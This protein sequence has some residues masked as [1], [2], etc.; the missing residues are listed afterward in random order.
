MKC[1]FLL[2]GLSICYSFLS[3]TME[4]ADSV[5]YLLA[6]NALA[7]YQ[8]AVM[9]EPLDPQ[10][11]SSALESILHIRTHFSLRDRWITYGKS[12]KECDTINLLFDDPYFVSEYYCT[13]E[14]S[15]NDKSQPDPLLDL[16]KSK[17]GYERFVMARHAINDLLAAAKN[18][19]P[20]EIT[21]AIEKMENVKSLFP[22]TERWG[23]TCGS[24]WQTDIEAQQYLFSTALKQNVLAK[25]M[26][27]IKN[28]AK[29]QETL[30]AASK[31]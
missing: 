9:Q 19:N 17:L 29:D 20:Q 13:N 11:I 22:L 3:F 6:Q 1:L 4:Q 25:L 27:R 10:N 28:D 12:E 30:T 21:H 7:E 26:S 16:I 14:R 5:K 18:A 31:V 23:I 15:K 24:Y 8:T 2:I